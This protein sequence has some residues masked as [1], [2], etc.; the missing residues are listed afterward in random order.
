MRWGTDEAIVKHLTPSSVSNTIFN[1]IKGKRNKDILDAL[2]A[3]FEWHATRGL[4]DLEQRLKL[5]RCCGDD[6]VRE[7]FDKL[8]N[9]REATFHDRQKYARRQVRVDFDAV[10]S[11]AIERH[12]RFRRNEWRIRYFRY[13][14]QAHN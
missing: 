1:K 6:N 2:K 14:D 7:H 9:M 4:V 12:C 11:I 8:A 10:V 13:R 5:A 3:L